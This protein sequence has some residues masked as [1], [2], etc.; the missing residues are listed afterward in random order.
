M[1]TSKTKI[2]WSKFHY[3]IFGIALLGL[4]S[5]SQTKVDKDSAASNQPSLSPSSN[6]YQ[7][8]NND[9]LNSTP[10]PADEP[11]INKFILI[12]NQVNKEIENLPASL[13]KK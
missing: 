9:W 3:L 5:C 12:Q 6:F 4:I 8:V 2:D 11:G 1:F 13:V 7:W 10:I